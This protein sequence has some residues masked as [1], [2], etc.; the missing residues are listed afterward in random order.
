MTLTIRT[1]LLLIAL[2]VFVIAA[3]G[4]DLGRLNL[5]ALGLAFLTAAFLAPDT[6]ISSRR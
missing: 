1:L 5:I 3:L 2:I 6:A 4:A